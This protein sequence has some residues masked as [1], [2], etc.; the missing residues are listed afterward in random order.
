[1][2]EGLLER[3]RL[4]DVA[5]WFGEMKRKQ[6]NLPL[7]KTE[8]EAEELP[9]MNTEKHGRRQKQRHGNKTLHLI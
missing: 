7:K 8:A 4:H 3:N 1:L 6:K 5:F 2:R 9:R